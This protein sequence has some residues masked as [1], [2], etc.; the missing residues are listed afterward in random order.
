MQ[1]SSD[2]KPLSLPRLAKCPAS[3]LVAFSVS[4][5]KS[6]SM[7]TCT[8]LL[9]QNMISVHVVT[10]PKLAVEILP[11]IIPARDFSQKVEESKIHSHSC[12][13]DMSLDPRNRITDAPMCC[14]FGNSRGLSAQP[15]H[16]FGTVSSFSGFGR[17]ATGQTTWCHHLIQS[18]PFCY[19]C[20]WRAST[21]ADQS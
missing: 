19:A 3:Q 20:A 16:S 14:L 4:L 12:N 18:L 1:L 15:T 9:A 21:R 17:L 2:L 7:P 11:N 6:G 10:S 8:G 13:G 5:R